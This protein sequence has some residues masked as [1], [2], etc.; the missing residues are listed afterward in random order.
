MFGSGDFSESI[1]LVIFESF[2]IALVL[3]GQF[4]N[5]QKSTRVI[6]P[7]LPSQTCDYWS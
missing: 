6:Y 4:Q 5:F 3:L 1:I 7:K 2:E